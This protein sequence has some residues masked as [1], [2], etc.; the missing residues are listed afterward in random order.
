MNKVGVVSGRFRLIHKAHKEVITRAT[1]EKIDELCIV[2]IDS[3]QTKRYSTISELRIAFGNILQHIDMKYQILILQ[4]KITSTTQLED[5]IIDHYQHRNIVMFDSRVKY[6]NQQLENKFIDCP[7]SSKITTASIEENPYEISNYENIATE[8]MPYINR[9]IVLS[10]TESSGKTQF[11]KK[12]S[13]IYN[14]VYSPEVGRFYGNHFLGGDDEAYSPK[15]FVFIAI[16]Q[17]KQDRL[18]NQ[19]A[20]RCLFVD[21]DPFVTLRFLTSYYQEYAARG[22][23][24]PE[25]IKEYDDAKQMLDSV[26]NTYRCDLI[27]L[28]APN[29]KYVDDGLRWQQSQ[30]ERNQRFQEL[31]AIYDY[32][33]MPYVIIDESGYQAR[34]A[35]VEKQLETYFK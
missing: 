11:C 3:P 33:K 28:L 2:V 4:E 19:D 5:L 32:Y 22:L 23:L 1:L 34:F 15:D 26:C 14:T 9:K 30:D 8:F 21:T 18:L 35:A 24:T 20:K 10:G 13:N 12:L 16:E 29:V 17:M 25:F 6:Q 7:L 31:V 27:L